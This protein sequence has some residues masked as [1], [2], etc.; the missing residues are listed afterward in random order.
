MLVEKEGVNN[1]ITPMERFSHVYVEGPIKTIFIFK[2]GSRVSSMGKLVVILVLCILVFEWS[3][4]TG[5]SKE[6]GPIDKTKTSESQ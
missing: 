5:D 4:K 6:D 3:S 1:Y 2:I